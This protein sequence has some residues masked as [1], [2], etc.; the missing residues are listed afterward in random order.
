MSDNGF[1]FALG[2]MVSVPIGLAI[3]LATPRLESWWGKRSQTKAEELAERRRDL[4]SSAQAFQAD[5][6]SFGV[7]LWGVLFRV[8]EAMLVSFVFMAVLLTL[9]AFLILNPGLN[10]DI[11]FQSSVIVLTLFVGIAV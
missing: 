7:H 2:V 8:V 6:L 1:F 4:R 5:P 10:S 11:Q 3:N 9:V